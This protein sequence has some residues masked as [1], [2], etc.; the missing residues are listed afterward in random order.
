MKNIIIIISLL[1]VFVSIGFE[2]LTN[3]ILSW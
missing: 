1:T 3:N 2:L